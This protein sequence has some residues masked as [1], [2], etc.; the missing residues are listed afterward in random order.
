MIYS[1]DKYHNDV[2]ELS[3]FGDIYLSYS[4]KKW[5]LVKD[6]SFCFLPNSIKETLEKY[7]DDCITFDGFT[8]NPKYEEV[9]EGVNLLKDNECSLIVAIG[10]GSTIDVAKCIKLFSSLDSNTNYLEQRN[11]Y[12]EG[13]NIGLVAIP[14]TA[15][16]GSESTR[17]AVIYYEGKKQSIASYKIVPNVVVLEPSVLISL[18]LNQKKYTLFD[19]FCQAME[20]WWSNSATTESIEYSKEAIKRIINCIDEYLVDRPSIDVCKEILLASNYA[21]RAINITATTAAHAMSY[22]IT[23]LYQYPHGY[24]VGICF[25]IVW[26]HMLNHLLSNEL[27]NKFIEIANSLGFDT[28][29]SAIRWF[30]EKLISLD[31]KSPISSNYENDIKTL[32]DSVNPERLS[33]NPIQFDK[34]ELEEMYKEIIQK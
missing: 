28:P 25:P 17:H 26:E 6:K 20:S 22:K 12:E 21:G 16:T 10:G 3:D 15:G 4:P 11:R 13:N 30:K 27:N 8:P 31:M 34:K 24:A 32:V 1:F 9:L 14:T 33:N 18:P 29:G 2:Y 7:G 5:M 19:A 23:S